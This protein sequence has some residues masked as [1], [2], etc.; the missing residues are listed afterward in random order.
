MLRWRW[1]K[2]LGRW[3]VWPHSRGQ[4]P[5]LLLV[6]AVLGLVNDGWHAVRRLWSDYHRPVV[7][8]RH[9]VSHGVAVSLNALAESY[10]KGGQ[11]PQ[12]EL[13]GV[14]LD[15][16]H[17]DWILF[18]EEAPQRPA[19]PRDAVAIALRALRHHLETPGIDIQ[20]QRSAGGTAPA[21]Q[22]VRYFGGVEGSVVGQW[23]FQFDYWM[24]RVS[25]AQEPVPTTDIP[26]YW[27]RAVEALERDVKACQTTELGVRVQRN[28]Y[29][30]CASDLTAL[31]GDDTLV[32]QGSPLRVLAERVIDT[33]HVGGEPATP[34][35]SRGT[36]DPLAAE[37]AARLTTHLPALTQVVPVAQ[38]EDFAR[39]LAGVAWLM[40]MDPYHD[41]QAW[42]RAPL[43]PVETPTTVPT[44]VMQ[45]VRE[46]T[47]TQSDTLVRHRHQL[48]LS[49]GVLVSPSLTRAR[50]GDN[51]PRL[52]YRAILM[53]RPPG[54]P[55]LWRFTFQPPST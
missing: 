39:L 47:C 41:V 1:P 17:N 54:K 19:L 23:F 45:A 51:S 22:E 5:A 49:G 12:F 38:I 31:E 3:L 16:A 2:V 48:E 8:Y 28:R 18:G 26:V 37:F 29:W 13:H 36:N 6:L 40:A 25:L 42:L 34:C 43:H 27:H 11:L 50:A 9:A 7:V 10:A 32:F 33:H 46:H 52:L 21:V 24:K 4:V 14:L 55:M 15:W 44:L 20:P 30:L 53:A 35:A